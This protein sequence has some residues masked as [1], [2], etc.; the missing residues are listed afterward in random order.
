M[1]GFGQAYQ[2]YQGWLGRMMAPPS[3]LGRF[4]HYRR[5]SRTSSGLTPETNPEV[6]PHH[7]SPELINSDSIVVAFVDA[8]FRE[9]VIEPTGRA[10]PVV[11]M[12]STYRRGIMPSTMTRK[13]TRQEA[14]D[15]HTTAQRPAAGAVRIN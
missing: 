9:P 13:R 12:T 6:G 14:A 8:E 1:D 4:S 3:Q 2:L 5:E 11:S 10:Y 15:V 7:A